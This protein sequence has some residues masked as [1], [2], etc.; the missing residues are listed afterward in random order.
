MREAARFLRQL[1]QLSWAWLIGISLQLTNGADLTALQLVKEGNRYV[2]EQ[3]KDKVVEIR[4][5]KSIAGLTPTI[6]RVVYYDS[7]AALKAVE[8]KFGAGKMLDVKRPFRLLEPVTGKQQP[9]DPARI[10]VDSDKAIQTALDEPLLQKLTIQAT[11]AKLERG[12]ADLPVW[13]VRLWAAKLRN[14]SE[15]VDI[16][17]V[18]ISADDG[19]VLK[20]ELRIKRVD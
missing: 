14:P 7:T 2:G 18:V 16:G 6:W 11:A 5:E 19:T 12:E 20:N 17:E 4:S 8:V 13:T 10:K 3:A 1:R 15:Q 9:L